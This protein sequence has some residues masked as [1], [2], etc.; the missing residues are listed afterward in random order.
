LWILLDFFSAVIS[1]VLADGVLFQ[2]FSVL[3]DYDF[4]EWL[5]RHGASELTLNSATLRAYYD[6]FFA[7][8]N[9]DPA[10]PTLAAG[11]ALYHLLRLT[12]T[13]KTS[14]FWEM[15]AGMGDAVVAPLYEVLERRGVKFAFFHRIES[16]GLSDDGSQV[17]TIQVAR[18]A[19]LKHGPYRPL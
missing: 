6:Y 10:R 4:R 16:L 9:G 5:A 11:V 3:D 2:G 15:Q 18:Q 8:E 17:A 14:I 13:Y 1:G 19:T 7:Y 12:F